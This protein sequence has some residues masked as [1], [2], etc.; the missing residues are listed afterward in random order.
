[1]K[2]E[3][4]KTKDPIYREKKEQNNETPNFLFS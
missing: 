2:F 3:I 1:M 4:K